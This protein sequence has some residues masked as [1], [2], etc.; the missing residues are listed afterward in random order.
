[1]AT[2]SPSATDNAK[3]QVQDKA[4]TAQEKA[5]SGAQQ[6]QSRVREQVDQRST[7]AGEQVHATADALR[8]TGRQ[9]REQ[10]QE[11]H[12]KAAD[13][14]AEHAER[15]GGYLTQSDADRIM[16]DAEDFGRRQ[17]MAVVGI[18]LALGFAASRFL[19]ASSRK[20]YEGGGPTEPS[21]YQAGGQAPVAPGVPYES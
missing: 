12:A 2:Q 10:G 3:Q 18:G 13:R 19:K 17:P 16:R 11:P 1:M 14:V 20:R 5:K 4:Q 21:G 9:L 15:L 6:A 8:A 7:Q